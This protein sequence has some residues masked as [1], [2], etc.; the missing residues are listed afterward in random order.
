[1]GVVVLR[2]GHRVMR[3]KRLTTHVALAARALG[4]SGMVMTEEDKNVAESVGDVV[5]RW[6][7]DFSLDF[8]KDWKGYI[9]SWKGTVVHLTMYGLPVEEVIEE[10]RK[11]KGDVLIVAGSEKVPR[12][13]YDLADYN[14]AVTN[15]PHSEVS[16]LSIFLDR[17]FSG[18]E[19]SL[20]F[21]GELEI[22]PSA[23]SK[24]VLKR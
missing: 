17:Y 2:L 13:A 10:V 19:L 5:E 18:K 8:V 11:Q 22:I 16:A 6:G 21:K 15:Q 4:A 3:D 20:D 14:V 24:K 23:N 1:M 12:E 9:K 7:G